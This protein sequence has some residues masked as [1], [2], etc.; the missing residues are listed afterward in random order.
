L[1]YEKRTRYYKKGI[2]SEKMRSSWKY[3][4]RK[5]KNKNLCRRL[6]KIFQIENKK[7]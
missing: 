6:K 4:Q 5:N 2:V 3:D 1:H 7:R